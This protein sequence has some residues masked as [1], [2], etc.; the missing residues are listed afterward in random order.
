MYMCIYIGRCMCGSV[1]LYDH[2][3]YV[4]VLFI[5]VNEQ[6]NVNITVSIR[7]CVKKKQ[8]YIFVRM[9]T[10]V[11]CVMHAI[12][13]LNSLIFC[14]LDRCIN[15][16]HRCLVIHASGVKNQMNSPNPLCQAQTGKGNYTFVSLFSFR[17]MLIST[18][19]FLTIYFKDFLLK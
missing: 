12:L 6:C 17:R 13:Q 11:Y 2:I 10:G 19:I 4:C 9:Y 15:W 7:L 14:T 3:F 18:V 1:S 8:L 16:R 5:V